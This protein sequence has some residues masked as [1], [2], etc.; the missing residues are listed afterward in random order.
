MTT[1]YLL[2]PGRR[3]SGVQK[4]NP[5]QVGERTQ[6]K[7]DLRIARIDAGGSVTV[8]IQTAPN[9]WNEADWAT[10]ITFGP[11]TATGIFTLDSSKVPTPDFT[12]TPRNDVYIRAVISATTKTAMFEVKADAPLFNQGASIDMGL[13]SQELRK[14][15]D[16][17]P[18]ILEEAEA[19]IVGLLKVDEESGELDIDLTAT[20]VSRLIKLEIADQAEHLMKR[21]VLSRSH[22]PSVL[23]TLRSMP[24][25]YPGAGDRLKIYRP[26]GGMI[27]YGR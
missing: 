6:W 7:I 14:W 3:W 27:W 18:R 13:L 2:L 25:L 15:G 9:Y 23:V 16:G 12:V 24:R 4:W 21:E 20:D 17:L 10:L 26:S 8:D 11:K 1:S 19:D 5:Y 22:E